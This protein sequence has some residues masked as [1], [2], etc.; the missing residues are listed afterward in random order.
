MA[1]V[2]I[3]PLNKTGGKPVLPWRTGSDFD[4]N[5]RAL[6]RAVTPPRFRFGVKGNGIN[7]LHRSEIQPVE[8]V[9]PYDG[10][11]RPE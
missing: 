5:T 1:H 10:H 6:R 8:Q 9:F 3:R 4:F 7:L 11:V 2:Q